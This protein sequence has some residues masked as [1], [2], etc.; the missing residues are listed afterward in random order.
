MVDILSKVQAP[1]V[2]LGPHISSTSPPAPLRGQPATST[3]P[4]PAPSLGGWPSAGEW[5][6]DIPSSLQRAPLQGQPVSS[7]SPQPALVRPPMS[8][9]AL[10]GGKPIS[11][12]FSHSIF[13]PLSLLKLEWWVLLWLSRRRLPSHGVWWWWRCPTPPARR[14]PPRISWSLLILKKSLRLLW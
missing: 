4:Q 14:V 10:L 12:S 6:T 9:S 2:G 11:T 1:L 5:L 7:S 3:S 8:T 13:I